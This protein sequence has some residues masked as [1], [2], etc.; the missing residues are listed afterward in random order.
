VEAFGAVK[1]AFDPEGILNPGVKLPLAGQDAI[2][3]IKYDPAL[4]PLPE[5]ASRALRTVER[6]RAYSTLRLDL[7]DGGG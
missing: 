3:D 1:R 5:R 6:D 7:L 2:G 4:P